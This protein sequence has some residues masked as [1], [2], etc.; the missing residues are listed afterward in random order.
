[1]ADMEDMA[2]REWTWN[3][4]QG[5]HE[6]PTLLTV[7]LQAGNRDGSW[8]PALSPPPLPCPVPLPVARCCSHLT[9]LLS[10]R[11]THI[12]LCRHSLEFVSMVTSHPTFQSVLTF[13]GQVTSAIAE[14]GI[15][16]DSR[17]IL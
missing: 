3:T 8:Y 13:T 1:M 16:E 7:T 10:C 14:I 12:F 15:A 11:L 2:V 5:A 6:E 17:E 9:R 4:W